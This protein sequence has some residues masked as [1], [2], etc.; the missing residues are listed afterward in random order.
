MLEIRSQR[1][2]GLRVHEVAGRVC[3]TLVGACGGG[4]QSVEVTKVL[5]SARVTAIGVERV[6]RSTGSLRWFVS[7][8]SCPSSIKFGSNG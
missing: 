4:L 3:W 1:S 5:S 8:V 6:D 7:Q 2:V